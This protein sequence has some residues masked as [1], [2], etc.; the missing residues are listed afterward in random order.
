MSASTK[1]GFE[2]PT[3]ETPRLILRSHRLS[4]FANSCAL[5]SD[6]VVTRHISGRAFTQEEVWSRLLR[7]IG[8]WSALG[9]GYWVIEEKATGDFI[10]ELGFADYKRTIDPPLVFPEAGWAL[11]TSAHG[12]GYATE[13]I[14]AILAWGDGNLPFDRTCCIINPEN[15]AS[16]RLAEKYGFRLLRDLQ[17]NGKIVS[18]FER[19][20]P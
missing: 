3:L 1:K 14:L 2:F 12:K 13:A 19:L 18:L 4:D 17:Y 15:A 20:R 8:H 10:G 5:W 9:Y 7:Y 16:I 6:P 11:A